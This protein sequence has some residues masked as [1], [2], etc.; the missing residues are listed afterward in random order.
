VD[1]LGDDPAADG[2]EVL[3]G[4]LDVSLPEAG[5]AATEN[6]TVSASPWGM[7]SF[8]GHRLLLI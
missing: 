6:S 2:A 5:Y 4:G 8:L 7:A 3:A 1:D